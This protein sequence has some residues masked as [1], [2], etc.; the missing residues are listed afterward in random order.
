MLLKPYRDPA[1][2]V[3]WLVVWLALPVVGIFVTA[4]IRTRPVR[5]IEAGRDHAS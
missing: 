3:A 2:R 1:A 4:A 5:F